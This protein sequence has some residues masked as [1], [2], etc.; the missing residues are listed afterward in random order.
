MLDFQG[1]STPSSSSLR[2]EAGRLFREYKQVHP[3][4]TPT[5]L[6]TIGTFFVITLISFLKAYHEQ[7]LPAWLILPF[8][9]FI[10]S[11]TLLPIQLSRFNQEKKALRPLETPSLLTLVLEQI[12][13]NNFDYA[14][15][16]FTS[17]KTDS[18]KIW[19]KI[20]TILM[21]RKE[22][23]SPQQASCL[24]ILIGMAQDSNAKTTK[25]PGASGL[26]AVFA[27]FDDDLPAAKRAI[28]GINSI[29][30][31]RAS[32]EMIRTAQKKAKNSSQR[33]NLME[34]EKRCLSKLVSS[35][36]SNDT[37]FINH[38]STA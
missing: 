30:V 19:A 33:N 5:H 1:V 6:A 9:L 24:D 4:L 34:V 8:A 13:A 23:S 12:T 36:F 27:V 2:S 35:P 7:D 16:L 29:T 18:P 17:I 21:S 26:A 25:M 3:R 14:S 32:L 10:L 20:I 22:A 11:A 31:A 15:T 38:S 28:E 37:S